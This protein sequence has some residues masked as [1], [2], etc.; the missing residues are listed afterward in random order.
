MTAS[1]RMIWLTGLALAGL[2]AL[3]PLAAAPRAVAGPVQQPT[4]TPRPPG[5]EKPPPLLLEQNATVTPFRLGTYCWDGLCADTFAAITA[6]EPLRVGRP[7][8]AGRLSLRYTTPPTQLSLGW[9]PVTWADVERRGDDWIAWPLRQG[10]ERA[11]QPALQQ[12]VSIDLYPGLNVVIVF[13]GW[14]QLADAMYALLVE[15][16]GPALPLYLPWGMR[17]PVTQ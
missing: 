1:R 17:P 4:A 10:R 15:V 16:G 6:P 13:G 12:D 5:Q 11:L 14:G 7:V 3:L 2:L 8:L 9:Y